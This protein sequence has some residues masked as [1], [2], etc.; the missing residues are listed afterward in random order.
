MHSYTPCTPPGCLYSKHTSRFVNLHHC[1][2]QYPCFAPSHDCLHLHDCSQCR[3]PPR[4][5]LSAHFPAPA[6]RFNPFVY[7]PLALQ[8]ITQ[9][10]LP[11]LLELNI[12]VPVCIL[13]HSCHSLQHGCIGQPRTLNQCSAC[14]CVQAVRKWLIVFAFASDAWCNAH[15][16]HLQHKTPT[17]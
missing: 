7:G 8:T 6:N 15:C 5:I 16:T 17:K 3:N 12:F 1:R 10:Q 2:K 14:M 4:A 11:A 9:Q 13:D